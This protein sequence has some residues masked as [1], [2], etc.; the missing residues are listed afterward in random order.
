MWRCCECGSGY[1][2]PRPNEASI[3]DAYGSYYTHEAAELPSAAGGWR[4]RL[5]NGYRNWRFGTNMQPS[6]QL[7]ILAS[8][9]A[10][11]LRQS[12]DASFRFLPNPWRGA[13]RRLIDFGCGDGSFLRL[14]QTAGWTCHGVEP[15]P[16][17]RTI[18]AGDGVDVRPSLKDF[19][20]SRFDAVT[21]SHVIE[22]VHD[23]VSL[24]KSLAAIMEKGAHL[25]IDTPN[26]LAVGH[27]IYGRHWR[28]LEAPR[29]LVLMTRKSLTAAL[30]STGFER[31]QYRDCLGA[32]EFTQLQSRRI[33]AGADPYDP[34]GITSGVVPVPSD[35]GYARHGERAEF[36][37]VT[38]VR[39]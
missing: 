27:R 29:H 8:L 30:V 16:A 35:Y 4:H 13:P 15:D 39:A 6:S 7:G 20:N 5:G 31:V 28:G 21:V 12:I 23:P 33:A 34:T 37:R 25:Y 38:A 24:L 14:A 10:P 32:L 26:M 9:A 2:D 11:A 18:A 36:L 17:A 3:G 22:H 1:L 19:Q